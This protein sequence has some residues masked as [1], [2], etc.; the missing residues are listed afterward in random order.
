M[1]TIIPCIDRWPDSPQLCVSPVNS[2]IFRLE[3]GSNV[4]SPILFPILYGGQIIISFVSVLL[5]L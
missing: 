1:S 2:L 4:L 3:T 5:T